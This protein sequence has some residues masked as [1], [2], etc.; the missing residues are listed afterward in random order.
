MF[1]AQ[2]RLQLPGSREIMCRKKRDN[3]ELYRCVCQE[4]LPH[5]A[6]ISQR[7]FKG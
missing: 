2:E 7:D 3:L 1:L 6:V 4:S 5:N